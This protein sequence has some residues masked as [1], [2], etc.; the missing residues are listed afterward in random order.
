MKKTEE[1]KDFRFAASSIKVIALIIAL[2]VMTI[3]WHA[4]IFFSAAMLP[5]IF[6]FFF[7]R[8]E[9]RCLSATICSFNLIGVMP[10]LMSLWQTNAIDYL[11]KQLLATPSTWMVIYGAAF[12]GQMLYVSVPLLIVK[13]YLAK[14][15]IKIGKY[16]TQRQALCDQWNIDAS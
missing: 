15:K 12:I 2:M 5:A 13:F 14:A 9:H 1:E 3:S 10:Y 16:K 6:A 11:A 4:F 8:N 7:D